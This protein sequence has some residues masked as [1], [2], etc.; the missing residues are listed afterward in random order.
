MRR[1]SLL[2]ALLFVIA[3]AACEVPP[4]T[5]PVPVATPT[6]EV[7]PTPEETPTP[8][9]TPTETP[10]PPTPTPTPTPTPAETPTPT[11]TPTD[12]D[13]PRGEE[14]I[15]I[16]EPGPGSRVV[17]PVTVRGISDPTFEQNLVVRILLEDGT[18]LA[19]EP[20]MIDAE[21]GER[22]E[23]EIDIEF[24][25]D[26]ETQAFIQVYDISAR[27]GGIIHLNSVGLTLAPDGPEDIVVTE[28][29]P[30]QIAIFE[31]TNNDTVS[32]G[33]AFVE[34]FALASFEQHL[35]V[36]VLDEWGDVV[37]EEPITVQAPDLGQPGPYS[38]EVT[39]TITSPQP[40]RIVVRD[41][42]VAFPGDSYLTS[43]EVQL[44]P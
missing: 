13:D 35:M 16:L 27:D 36:E 26:V 2:I 38:A 28:P 14:A 44:E 24:D 21:L 1:I 3:L 31:P 6:P 5:E 33:V 11:P 9:P 41:P 18:E 20:T 42:S 30:E 40:G 32:G 25:V 34:G 19:L 29:Q 15:V 7:T 8:T 17:S 39:Y 23:Y 43:V 12:P 10:V 4:G 37:G 22:G